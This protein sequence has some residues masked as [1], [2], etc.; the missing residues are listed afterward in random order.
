MAPAIRLVTR[1]PQGGCPLTHPLTREP[2]TAPAVPHHLHH[3]DGPPSWWNHHTGQCSSWVGA[4]HVSYFGR[5]IPLP[6]HDA[7]QE[8]EHFPDA[9]I[10]HHEV[11]TRTSR[12]QGTSFEPGGYHRPLAYR[13]VA[14]TAYM[15]VWVLPTN[16]HRHRDPVPHPLLHQP[17]ERWNLIP[18]TAHVQRREYLALTTPA[19]GPHVPRP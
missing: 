15:E 13:Q 11:V 4:L 18:G 3:G 19:G 10:L 8:P 2:C 1:P 16:D 5:F 17:L 9:L 7:D 6:G 14:P 12:G